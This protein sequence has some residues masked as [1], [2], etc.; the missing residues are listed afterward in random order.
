M[1]ICKFLCFLSQRN[2]WGPTFHNNKKRPF[3]RNSNGLFFAFFLYLIRILLFFVRF[4][5]RQNPFRKTAVFFE[6]DSLMS[7]L[8]ALKIQEYQPI[9]RIRLNT[10]RLIPKK[11]NK[12]LI[13][14]YLYAEIEVVMHNT[15]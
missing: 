5:L 11:A 6:K 7:A 1:K 8:S 13:I 10:N 9:W 2:F 4:N 12:N 14:K 15:S 3:E